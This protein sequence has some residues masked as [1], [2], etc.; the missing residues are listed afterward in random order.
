MRR[1]SVLLPAIIAS[2]AGPAT[3]DAPVIA[4]KKY[5]DSGLAARVKNVMFDSFKTSTESFQ[6][7]AEGFAS[8]AQGAR[9]DSAMQP[10]GSQTAKTFYAAPSGAGGL[11]SFRAITAADI[12]TL[13]QNTTGS[14]AKLTTARTVNVNLTGYATGSG[15]V[16]FDGSNNATI[17][18]PT[19]GTSTDQMSKSALAVNSVEGPYHG[20]WKAFSGSLSIGYNFTCVLDIVAGMWQNIHAAFGWRPAEYGNMGESGHASIVYYGG[21]SYDGLAVGGAAD[22]GSQTSLKIR[23]YSTKDTYGTVEIWLYAPNY[24]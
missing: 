1:L 6:N 23:W 5:V 11:P 17:N 9:A 10:F 19:S 16:S 15:S 24:A 7:R 4:T 2:F 3:G 14:A 22:S 13:N 18:I 8:A 12:P 20:W 21:G